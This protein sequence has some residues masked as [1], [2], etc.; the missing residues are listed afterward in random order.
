MLPSISN[1]L[2]LRAVLAAT[3]A[4]SSQAQHSLKQVS[5]NEKSGIDSTSWAWE[6]AAATASDSEKAGRVS[7]SSS[8]QSHQSRFVCGIGKS[9]PFG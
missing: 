8:G 4:A 6:I 7:G 3:L 2:V 5:S 1:V 9:S